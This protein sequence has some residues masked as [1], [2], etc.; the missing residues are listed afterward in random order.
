MIGAPKGDGLSFSL[1]YSANPKSQTVFLA[2]VDEEEEI[3]EE[4]AWYEAEP[5][6]QTTITNQISPDGQEHTITK[7]QTSENALPG[8]DEQIITKTQVTEENDQNGEANGLVTMNTGDEIFED[9]EERLDLFSGAEQ[10]QPE[11]VSPDITTSGIVGEQPSNGWN[12]ADLGRYFNLGPSS[13][14]PSWDPIKSDLTHPQLD[15]LIA[16]IERELAGASTKDLFGDYGTGDDNDDITFAALGLGNEEESTS[17]PPG[18]IPGM[19]LK[20]GINLYD[21]LDESPNLQSNEGATTWNSASN[22]RGGESAAI[23]PADADSG[24]FLWSS[25]DE[26][27]AGGI[28]IPPT[29]GSFAELAGSEIFLPPY[30]EG[31]NFDSDMNSNSNRRR[32]RGTLNLGANPFVLSQPEDQD[33]VVEEQEHF[34][35]EDEVAVEEDKEGQV[36]FQEDTGEIWYNAGLPRLK[37]HFSRG[38]VRPEVRTGG[39]DFWEKAASEMPGGN[40]KP[41]RSKPNRGRGRSGYYWN[42]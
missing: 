15:V 38:Q 10:L 40:F 29:I 3:I 17:L 14:S 12:D 2:V 26:S 9:Q 4:E 8:Y 16:D 18:L 35:I 27:G 32:S 39:M 33:Q 37:P 41:T 20:K 31:A 11:V 25:V 6:V 23:T 5:E 13:N 34:I 28:G 24:P 36:D 1:R 22:N 19:G 42:Q 7:T 21:T 30:G